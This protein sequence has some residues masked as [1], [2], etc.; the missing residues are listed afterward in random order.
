MLGI[1]FEAQNYLSDTKRKEMDV[2]YDLVNLMLGTYDFTNWLAKEES[3]DTTL[4]VNEKKHFRN[5]LTIPQLE[6]NDKV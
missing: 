2:K 4:K 1:Y 6:G 5:I 3:G